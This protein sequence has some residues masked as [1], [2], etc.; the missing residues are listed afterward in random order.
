MSLRHLKHMPHVVAVMTPFPY[1]VDIDATLAEADAMMRE[2]RIRHLPVKDQGQL[3]SV[4]SERDIKV[5]LEPANGALAASR[6][7]VRHACV[8]DAYIVPTTA[9]LDQVLLDMYERHI[10]SALV[11]KGGRLAGI[12]TASDACRYLGELLRAQFPPPGDGDDAA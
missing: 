4:L 7:T 3:V 9:P 8:I 1:S 5:A 11:V 10:G 6:V 12:F 2:H